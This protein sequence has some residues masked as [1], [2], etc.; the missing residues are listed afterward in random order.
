MNIKEKLKPYRNYIGV[1]LLFI[2]LFMIS[3]TLLNI[4]NLLDEDLKIINKVDDNSI[5]FEYFDY[6]GDVQTKQL[7][8]PTWHKIVY[9]ILNLIFYLFFANLLYGKIVYVSKGE[10]NN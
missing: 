10:E 6:V 1:A 2:S 8:V 4:K 7:E 9:E 3:Y 5:E